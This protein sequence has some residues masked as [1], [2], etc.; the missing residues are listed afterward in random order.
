MEQKRKLIIKGAMEL[1]S[2][3]GFQSTSM[4]EIADHIGVAKGSL[5][6]YFNSKLEL[7][8]QIFLYNYDF[9]A[10]KVEEIETTDNL[11]SREKFRLQ[12]MV[13][14][15]A[16]VENRDFVRQQCQVNIYQQ[17]DRIKEF[18]VKV[19]FESLSW[20]RMK[21]MELYGEDI[22]PYSLDLATIMN[23]IVNEYL[24]Y[25]IID[26]IQ[27]DLEGF[28]H[29][30]IEQCDILVNG[31]KK[32]KRSFLTEDV[33]PPFEISHSSKELLLSCQSKLSKLEIDNKD[34]ISHTLEV[35]VEEWGKKETKKVVLESVLFRLEHLSQGYFEPEITE[36]RK[37]LKNS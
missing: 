27:F 1:F 5:Y 34:E 19:R 17:D 3:K 15:S 25:N 26:G 8:Y 23:G 33:L 14:L 12:V 28:S 11:S 35:L 4:Q 10:N 30:V 24:S 9:F 29:F 32:G 20:T 7:L 2:K 37:I 22:K 21:M 6:H 31:Y 36:L 18:F 16:F 13:Q